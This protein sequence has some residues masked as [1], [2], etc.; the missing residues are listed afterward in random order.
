MNNL[1]NNTVGKARNYVDLKKDSRRGDIELGEVP[2]ADSGGDVDLT[3]FFEEVGVIKS[4]MDKIKQLLEKVKVANDESRTVHRAQ[5]MKA[6]RSRMDADILQV[7]KIA[8]AIKV[9]LELLDRAN[10]ESRRVRGCEEGSPTDRTRTSITSTLRKKLKDLMGEF[11]ILRQRMMEEYKE[12]VER[13]YFTVTGQQ[14]DD[15][16]IENIIETGNSETFLQKAI[17]EQGR[18]QVL[19]TIKEIQERHDAVKDI[20]KNL[21]E[22]NQIFMDMATLVEAQGEQLNDI[23]QHVN[24]ATSFVAAG[25]QQLKVAKDHQRSTRKCVCIAIALVIVLI[26]IILLPILHTVGAL[27]GGK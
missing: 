24:R 16:T 20:E 15:E 10:A 12:T 2:M 14:A 8:R 25:T 9:K 6:L 22:L 21:I 19:E 3:Q 1:L 11:Q 18:G 7:T 5:A 17:Q 13:R 27:G 26:L 23:E 4:D